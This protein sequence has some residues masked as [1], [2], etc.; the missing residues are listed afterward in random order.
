MCSKS[1]TKSVNNN[2]NKMQFLSCNIVDIFRTFHD[3]NV[4]NFISF[5]F[6]L[7]KRFSVKFVCM[8]FCFV[9]YNSSGN[10]FHSSTNMCLPKFIDS[11]MQRTVVSSGSQLSLSKESLLCLN[12][13]NEFFLKKCNVEHLKKC[14]ALRDLVP[15]VQFK[16]REKHPW[17]SVTFSTTLL[18]VTLLHGCFSRFLNCK[19]G[20][21]SRKT[22]TFLRQN[23]K[24]GKV[25]K[26]SFTSRTIFLQTTQTLT[27]VCVNFYKIIL[28]KQRNVYIRESNS[29]PYFACHEKKVIF[30]KKDIKCSLRVTLPLLF[31]LKVTTE[32]QN[33][34]SF[35]ERLEICPQAP[36]LLHSCD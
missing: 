13:K 24:T 2:V 36:N 29:I 16:K 21:K 3:Y 5:R 23:R 9:V 32:R 6:F 14:D 4:Y 26:Q 7:T 27:I 30:L 15:F 31:R 28:R 10:E 25:R 18:R 8:I 1:T 35:S 22:S 19:N 17:R 12:S 34:L 33:T 11:S 20:T